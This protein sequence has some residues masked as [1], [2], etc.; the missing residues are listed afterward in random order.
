[1]G[2]AAGVIG[3]RTNPVVQPFEVGEG[4]ECL[5]LGREDLRLRPIVDGHP[6]AVAELADHHGHAPRRLDALQLA[7]AGG[8]GGGRVGGGPLGVAVDGHPAHP[9]DGLGLQRSGVGGEEGVGGADGGDHAVDAGLVQGGVGDVA[10]SADEGVVL[11]GCGI[12]GVAGPAVAVGGLPVEAILRLRT[13]IQD[14]AGLEERGVGL[15]EGAL[16]ILVGLGG[17]DPGGAVVVAPLVGVD[18]EPDVPAGGPDRLHPVPH[19]VGV[20]VVGVHRDVGRREAC[21]Q[22]HIVGDLG[23]CEGAG[24]GVAALLHSVDGREGERHGGGG[25]PGAEGG[26]DGREEGGSEERQQ[27]EG[28]NDAARAAARGWPLRVA[29]RS[30]PP[31]A[32][33]S[34]AVASPSGYSACSTYGNSTCWLSFRVVTHVSTVR[35]RDAQLRFGRCGESRS[36]GVTWR[37]CGR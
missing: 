25:V 19:V 23:V 2:V 8:G 30:V 20:F 4:C 5:E 37:D 28:P 36:S 22:I 21:G 13:G 12:W 17:H 26:I 32:A 15:E 24:F 18:A 3:A 33:Y 29:H 7:Q 11:A 1:M 10:G 31:S 9:G 16:G 14:V 6:V 35:V 34:D 27:E